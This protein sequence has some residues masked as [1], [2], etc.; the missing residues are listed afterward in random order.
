M[1]NSMVLHGK[2][3]LRSSKETRV[4]HKEKV[5]VFVPLYAF[6]LLLFSWTPNAAASWNVLYQRVG[7]YGQAPDQFR[8]VAQNNRADHKETKTPGSMTGRKQEDIK[9]Q[10]KG[11]KKE[12]SREQKSEP[13]KRFVP[14]KKIEADQ[15]VD[16]P[17]DI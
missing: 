2:S 1:E 12:A 3:R 17:N 5:Y 14:S 9:T 7:D 13:L 16:F 15:A 11:D 4:W 6:S 10:I 8:L